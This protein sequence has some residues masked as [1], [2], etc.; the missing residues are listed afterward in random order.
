[1]QF[2]EGGWWNSYED[3]NIDVTAKYVDGLVTHI[4]I[5]SCQKQVT[6]TR[7]VS[8][9]VRGMAFIQ[10]SRTVAIYMLAAL[11]VST[12]PTLSVKGDTKINFP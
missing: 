3:I 8:Y 7:S 2:N 1:M 5:K 10:E 11:A 12:V 9:E 4:T 6:L